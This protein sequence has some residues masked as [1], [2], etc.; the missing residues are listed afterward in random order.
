MAKFALFVGDQFKRVRDFPERPV[1]IPHK[2]VKWYPVVR[3]VVDNSTQP[4]TNTNTTRQVEGD[5]YVI[6][7]TISDMSQAEID[8]FMEDRKDDAVGQFNRDLSLTKA[9]GEVLFELVNDV[10]E[11]KGQQAITKQQFISYVKGKL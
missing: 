6:R 8:A 5:N 9:L 4:Y 3:E 1:D 2:N 11:L 10:R 7:K